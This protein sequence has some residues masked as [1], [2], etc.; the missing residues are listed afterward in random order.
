MTHRDTE[1]TY[2]QRILRVMLHIEE[3]LDGDLSLEA[4][5]RLSCFSPY[6]FH[7]IFREVA[8]EPLG[9]Y[10]RRLRLERSAGRLKQT[11]RSVLDIALEAG[12]EAHESFTR[13][14]R[15]MFGVSPSA[16]RKSL[17]VVLGPAAGAEREPRPTGALI[18]QVKVEKL[19][20]RRIAAIRHVGPYVQIG[21]AFERLCAWAGPRQLFGPDTLL[22]GIFHHDPEVT[23]AEKLRSDAA[24]TVAEGV[25]GDGEVTIGE[26]AG[27]EYAVVRHKG[28]YTKLIDT[29]RW[30]YGQ[31][32]PTSGREPGDAPCFE[33]YLSDPSQVK[34][35]DLE[36]D[37]Y[38]PL[39]TG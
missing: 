18:M 20:P 35:E 22:L 12:F 33:V 23:P 17:G 28:E 30:I 19:P 6:H 11:D 24:L 25:E 13:V 14:F 34:P 4:M 26:L 31:W 2:R 27:G 1:R 3:H 9:R 37:V 16:Y 21:G 10:V 15:E 7:R 39:K 32:L 36:T 29:Y 38:V 8:G 5:A